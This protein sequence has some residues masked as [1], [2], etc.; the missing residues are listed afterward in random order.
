MIDGISRSSGRLCAQTA[1]VAV[2]VGSDQPDESHVS[3][4]L[5]RTPA[6]AVNPE[7][8]LRRNVGAAIGQRVHVLPRRGTQR[9][10]HA[11]G[12]YRDSH[13]RGQQE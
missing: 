2:K 9:A 1:E 5:R 13:A 11:A 3:H 8:R 6:L 12:V 10:R 7:Q 4:D